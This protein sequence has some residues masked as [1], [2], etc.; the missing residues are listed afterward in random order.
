MSFFI[1]SLLVDEAILVFEFRF[2]SAMVWSGFV[3][4]SASPSS[5]NV[6]TK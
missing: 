3:L 6:T 2:L 4:D 1:V 5:E